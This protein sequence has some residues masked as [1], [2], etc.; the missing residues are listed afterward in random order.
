[1]INKTTRLTTRAFSISIIDLSNY[2]GCRSIIVYFY[3]QYVIKQHAKNPLGLKGFNV[4]R[5]YC[6]C[7]YVFIHRWTLTF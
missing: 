2:E 3:E 1:M 6:L 4:F 5:F 7:M